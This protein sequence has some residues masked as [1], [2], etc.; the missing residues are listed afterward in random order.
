[1]PLVT[2]M[3]NHCNRGQDTQPEVTDAYG[4]DTH[5]DIFASLRERLLPRFDQ[6]FSALLEDLS[7]RGMLEDTLV[8]CFGEFGRAPRVALEPKFAGSS[9][10]RKHWANAYSIVMAGAGV[11]PGAVHGATDSIGGDVLDSPVRPGDLVA[12]LFASLGVNPAGHYRDLVERP[13]PIATGRP[14]A[15]LF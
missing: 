15:E 13:F 10:G 5:N 6:S 8:I 9:P 11:K 4:W 3:F 12:T 7:Q 2:V 1:M 14:V